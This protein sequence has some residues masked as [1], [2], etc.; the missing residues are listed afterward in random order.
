MRESKIS[1]AAVAVL[2]V[3]FVSSCESRPRMETTKPVAPEPTT[4]PQTA[5]PHSEPTLTGATVKAPIAVMP[6]K[7]VFGDPPP[8]MPAGARVAIL[9]GDPSTPGALFTVRAKLPP[10]YRF[11]PHS[12]PTDEHVTVLS[13]TL[14]VGHGDHFVKEEMSG[15]PAGGYGV[16]PAGH[17]HYAGTGDKEAVIQIHAM[18]PLEFVYVNPADDPRNQKK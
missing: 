7:I 15:L 8:M 10:N 18:G 14:N 4:P 17:H 9:E 1:V 13:G 6:D 5:T 16:M 12:H 11:M 2:A 3:A